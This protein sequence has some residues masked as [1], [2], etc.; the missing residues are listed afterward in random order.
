MFLIMMTI[1]M[2]GRAKVSNYLDFQ[3]TDQWKIQAVINIA[4]EIA[5]QN[6]IVKM[7][8][9]FNTSKKRLGINSQKL[10]FI[11][12][13][14]FDNK[15]LIEDSKIIK[16]EALSNENRAEIFKF[17]KKYPG[18][19]F[20]ALKNNVLP[21]SNLGTGQIIWHLEILMNFRYINKMTFK[22]YTL[23]LPYE[24]A[25]EQALLYFLLRDRINRKIIKILNDKGSMKQADIPQAINESKGNIY[26]HIKTLNEE[27]L[28]ISEKI[29][30]NL[31]ARLNAVNK[32]LL[33]EIIEDVENKLINLKKKYISSISDSI[34]EIVKIQ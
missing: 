9:L 6:K 11:L 12:K 31:E 10:K 22:K 33:I 25:P 34:E 15:I 20:S 19:N 17:I 13:Y 3:K 26:Y 23:Y 24:M 18:V 27:K 16:S 32:D 14:L 7:E 2:R 1:S 21:E 29:S 8:K 4:K 30:G 5:E 28:L